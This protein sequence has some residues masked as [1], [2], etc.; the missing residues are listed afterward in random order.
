MHHGFIE[1]AARAL[2]RERSREGTGAMGNRLYVGNLSFNTSKETLEAAFAA[3]GQVREVHLVTD[4]ESGQPRGFGFVTMGSPA[5]AANAIAKLD[6]STLDGRQ[7]K[8]DEARERAGGGGDRD[9]DRGR[10]RW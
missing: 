8:V 9:R 5:D 2:W 1:S 6:G 7:L 4:R 3:T 10:A